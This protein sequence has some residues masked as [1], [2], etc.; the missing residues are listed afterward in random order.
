MTLVDIRRITELQISFE[1]LTRRC[2]R[3]YEES[4]Q[5]YKQLKNLSGMQQVQRTLEYIMEDVQEECQLLKLMDG[6]LEQT[7]RTFAVSEEYITEH[8]EESK[9]GNLKN[10]ILEAVTIPES[11][12]RLLR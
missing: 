5:T 12:F 2:R 3:L 4:G 10:N 11:I 8:A 9:D 1:E 7:C 6:C